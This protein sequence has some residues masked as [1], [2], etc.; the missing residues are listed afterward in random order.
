MHNNYPKAIVLMH[1]LMFILVLVVYFSSGDPTESGFI[2]QIHVSGGILIFI[3]TFIRL[4]LLLVN[5]HRIPQ[6]PVI[7][8]LQ[9]KLFKAMKWLL[10]LSLLI[11]PIIGWFALSVIT[12][13]YTVL[14]WSLPLLSSLNG[15]ELIAKLHELL[16]NVFITLVGLHATAALIH[17]F[18][19]KDRVLKSMTLSGDK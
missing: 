7:S 12:T 3:L 14:S 18:I 5:K 8:P 19:F 9:W 16:G 6:Q 11:V 1:W 2:G 15:V 13:Q 4:L 10:Y 17:H